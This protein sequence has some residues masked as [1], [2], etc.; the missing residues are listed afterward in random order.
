MEL[1]GPRSVPGFAHSLKRYTLEGLPRLGPS[2]WGPWLAGAVALRR[3][4]VTRTPL[5]V[6]SLP[7]SLPDWVQM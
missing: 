4:A 5:D 3:V 2:A 7:I 1:V 6:P